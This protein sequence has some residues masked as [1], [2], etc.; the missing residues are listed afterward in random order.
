MLL[1]TSEIQDITAATQNYTACVFIDLVMRNYTSE[2]QGGAEEEKQQKL[3]FV[4]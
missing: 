2:P 1:T 4:I 3:K